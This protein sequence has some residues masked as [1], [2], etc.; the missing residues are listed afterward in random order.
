[1]AVIASLRPTPD[2]LRVF[3][4]A[5]FLSANRS[6]S[7]CVIPHTDTRA[8]YSPLTMRHK[9]AKYLTICNARNPERHKR[10]KNKVMNNSE[11]PIGRLID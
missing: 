2:F 5:C 7:N 6:H 1:M 10:K 4:L 3:V 8:G 9:S 11:T